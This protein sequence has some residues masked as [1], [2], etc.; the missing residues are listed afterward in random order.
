MGCGNPKVKLEDEL[1]IL[2]LERAQIQME[3]VNQLKLLDEI[4]GG[5][6]KPATIPDY[7]APHGKINK[8]ENHEKSQKHLR[9]NFKKPTARRSL[10]RNKSQVIK[11]KNKEEKLIKRRTVKFNSSKLLVK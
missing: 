3:R 6:Y 9:F 5:P 7:I 10:I 1:M 11:S 4:G 8:I 2:K